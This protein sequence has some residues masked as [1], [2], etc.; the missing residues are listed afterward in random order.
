M[1]AKTT[2]RVER[3]PLAQQ[4]PQSV[5]G[6][7]DPNF[8]YRFVNDTVTGDSDQNLNIMSAKLSP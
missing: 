4:G 1:N 8:S 2:K 5:A 7:K 3:K 6:D